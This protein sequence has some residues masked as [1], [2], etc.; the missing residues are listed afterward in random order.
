[1]KGNGFSHSEIHLLKQLEN[2]TAVNFGQTG[3]VDLNSTAAEAID[4]AREAF[5]KAREA[6]IS[7]NYDL[8]VLDELNPATYFGLIPLEDVL[9]LI[10]DKPEELEL[11][12]TGRYALPELIRAADLVTEMRMIKHPY[13]S[14][15]LARQGIDY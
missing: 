8:V 13:Y 6:V 2:V 15:I 9:T 5:S 12:L 7:A 11:I 3:W 10:R 14:G 1:M 4:Q